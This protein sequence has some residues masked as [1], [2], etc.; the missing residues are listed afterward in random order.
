MGRQSGIGGRA[1]RALVAALLVVG[2]VVAASTPIGAQEPP[3]DEPDPNAF[4]PPIS[5]VANPRLEPNAERGLDI[6]IVLDLSNSIDDTELA[7]L[8]T[9]AQNFVTALQGTPSNVGVYNFA[10]FAP[11]NASAANTPLVFQ[12]VATAAGATTARNKITGLTR[13]VSANGGTNWDRGI[14]QVTASGQDYDALLFLTD[15]DP[16]AFGIPGNPGVP[17]G[18]NDFGTG[19]D[20]VDVNAAVVSANAV[21]AA[22]TRMIAVGIGTGASPGSV[23]RLQAISGPTENSDYWLTNFGTLDAVLRAIASGTCD[24]HVLIN[25]VVRNVDGTTVPGAGWTFASS[26]TGVTPASATTQAAGSV[27]FD[28]DFTAPADPARPVTIT[29]TLL[30]GFEIG[31]GPGGARATCT[32]DDGTPV[33][34]TNVGPGTGFQLNVSPV[35]DITCTVT[36][37]QLVPPRLTLVKTVTNDN[38]G[39]ALP[40]AWTLSAAGPTP[41]SGTSGAT[42]VTDAT[43]QPGTYT[44]AETAGPAGYQAGAWSCTD[45]VLTGS[46]L[47]LAFG[48]V[49]TC[50]INNN[51]IAAQLTLVKALVQDPASPTLPTA[52][53]LS[54]TGPTP[55]SGTTG[56]AAV[57]D[58]PVNAGS[59]ALAE[60]GGPAGYAL[61]GWACTGATLTGTTVTIPLAADVT[62]TATNTATPSWTLAKQ[63]DPATGTTVLPGGTITYTLTATNTSDAA[64]TGMTVT[65]DLTDVL[66]DAAVGTITP[67]AGTASVGADD[68]LTWTGISLPARGTASLTYVVTVDPG[69]F[70]ASLRNVATGTGSTRRPPARPAAS[71]APRSTTP[72]SPRRSRWSRS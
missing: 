22:G 59:Y 5:A 57:T 25:K 27:T 38:G 58:A 60:T 8:R 64:I 53:T 23:Q 69:A 17:V 7:Q 19:V 63:S 3:I 12:S 48:D 51:D 4:I 70:G 18:N 43:V 52:W 47:V 39:T 65:D 31:L 72:R 41:I 46:S 16:T 62:C 2:V 45:G 71:S 11:A 15:G 26:G 21:K 40:T 44:L 50:T 29:E 32:F 56:A 35:D 24:G 1:S 67:S 37:N 20:Q 68:V 61:T 36:N 42:T 9:A 55:I 13:P 10:T 28:V 6:A 54:A 34:V 49:A 30:P 33:P 66:D 14:A